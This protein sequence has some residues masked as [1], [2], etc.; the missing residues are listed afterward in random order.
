[1]SPNT[2]PTHHTTGQRLVACAG[3]TGALALGVAAPALAKRPGPG[4]GAAGA[5]TLQGPPSYNTTWPGYTPPQ[6]AKPVPRTPVALSSEGVQL[7]QVGLGAVG[8]AALAGAGAMALGRLH[9]R[10]VAAHA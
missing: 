2:A 3:L 7:V 1:M 6:L 9:R 10:S 8:G 5:A 4:D